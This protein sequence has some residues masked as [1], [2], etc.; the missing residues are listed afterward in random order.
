MR[1]KDIDVSENSG[2]PKSS[3]LIG[4]SII[5]HPFWG[6]PIFGNTHINN[7]SH[8]SP[9]WNIASCSFSCLVTFWRM[10]LALG[11]IVDFQGLRLISFLGIILMIQVIASLIDLSVFIRKDTC[12]DL[13][14][15]DGSQYYQEG[16]SGLLDHHIIIWAFSLSLSLYFMF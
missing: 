9:S 10:F 11:T 1:W 8:V 3:I 7:T 2:T 14:L 13:I 12:W 6:T 5:N 16:R 4:F 15:F